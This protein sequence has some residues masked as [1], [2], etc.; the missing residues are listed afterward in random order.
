MSQYSR[1]DGVFVESP[2]TFVGAVVFGRAGD[3]FFLVLPC[4]RAKVATSARAI[5]SVL[6]GMDNLQI[7]AC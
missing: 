1:P 3:A 2:V 6:L 7:S 4:A 5:N